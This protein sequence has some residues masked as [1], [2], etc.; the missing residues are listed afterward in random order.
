M[1]NSQ[2]PLFRK[3][4]APW[5]DSELACIVII[6]LMVPVLFFGGL[7]ISAAQDHPD[8]QGII[9]VPVILMLLSLFVLIS[10]IIRLIKRSRRHYQNLS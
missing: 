5:Y 1:R 4:I 2:N 7:G 3:V 10:T 9:W 6:V 8:Y